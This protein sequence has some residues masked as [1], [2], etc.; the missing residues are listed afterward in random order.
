MLR[1]NRE[2]IQEQDLER[3]QQKFPDLDLLD[4]NPKDSYKSSVPEKQ[5]QHKIPWT[6][7][8]QALFIEALELYG[9]KSKFFVFIAFRTE[10]NVRP[11]LNSFCNLSA[12]A[13]SE[14]LIEE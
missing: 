2:L 9:A 1:E 14:A 12:V 5:K 4:L 6:D 10:G 7:G 8:E 3:F 11:R 13:S